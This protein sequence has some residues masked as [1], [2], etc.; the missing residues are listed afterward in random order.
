MAQPRL[1]AVAPAQRR[2]R[3]AQGG[4]V[5]YDQALENVRKQ[6]GKD[7]EPEWATAYESGDQEVI[8][9]ITRDHTVMEDHGIDQWNR[10]LSVHVDGKPRTSIILD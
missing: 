5:M 9:L 3:T 10:R 8:I 4:R 7:V 6:L 1:P 2:T